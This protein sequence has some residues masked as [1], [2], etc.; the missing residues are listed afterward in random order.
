MTNASR[1]APSAAADARWIASSVRSVGDPI[2]AAA[3]ATSGI[4]R[5][6]DDAFED[7]L[8]ARF[9]DSRAARGGSPDLHEADHARRLRTVVGDE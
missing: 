7:V 3:A 6:P 2:V 8:H 1:S 4:E 9:G 5:D